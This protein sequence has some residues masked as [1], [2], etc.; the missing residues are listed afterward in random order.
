MST[1]SHFRLS[2]LA[3]LVFASAHAQ[4]V[5]TLTDAE[6]SQGWQL[7][8]DGKALTGWHSFQKTSITESGWV[9]KDS[10]IY[11]RGPAVGALLAPENFVYRNFEISIDWKISD[12]RNS[13][14]F[15]RYLESEVSENIRTGPESQICGKL[16]PDY[17]TGT[18]L[19]SPGACYAMYKPANPWI[20]SSD[21]YNTFHVVM[22]ENRVAH[23]GNGTRLLEY[24]IGSEDWVARYEKSKYASFPLY[25]DIHAGKLFL[26]DHAHP[27]WYRNIKIRPLTADPWTTTDFTWPDQRLG[28][29]RRGS[30]VGYG[31]RVLS[32]SNGR[33][34]LSLEKPA[35][36]D[37]RL[38]DLLGRGRSASRGYGSEA[39]FEARVAPGGY[40]LRGTLDGSP[41]GRAVAVP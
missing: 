38:G 29:V 21:Q 36:W 2:V 40:W 19:T 8:F 22:Y 11:L 32:A 35:A 4:E 10:A 15:L 13:G 5:N 41:I 25:G 30:P 14:I 3:F 20:R 9:I 28:I 37:L 7:M 17:K 27:V 31:M 18:E 6:K 39:A 24:V 1:L 33:L 12:N 26:Q 16:H 23:F 34:R